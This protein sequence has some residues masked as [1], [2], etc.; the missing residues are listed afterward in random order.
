MIEKY[1]RHDQQHD[2]VY[3]RFS[4]QRIGKLNNFTEPLAEDLISFPKRP[5]LSAPTVTSH[6]RDSITSSDS[7]VG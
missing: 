2:H 3:E 5:L 1:V 4:E 7:G 6:K